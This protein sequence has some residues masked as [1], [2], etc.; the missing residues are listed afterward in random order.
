MSFFFLL[1]LCSV[2]FLSIIMSKSLNPLPSV[3]SGDLLISSSLSES[4][5]AGL[6]FSS[7]GAAGVSAPSP[8]L[9]DIAGS[10]GAFPSSSSE[11]PP[12]ASLTTCF[13]LFSMSLPDLDPDRDLLLEGDLDLDPERDF[14]PDFD[15][16]RDLDLD[17]ERDLDPDLD[18]ERDLD[19]ELDLER[20]LEPD[21]ERDLDLSADLERLL[22][23]DRL[24]DLERLLDLDGDLALEPDLLLLLLLLPSF[25]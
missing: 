21:L 22:D 17:L 14:D 23:L 6:L 25:D 19:L 20:D 18:L 13:F 2:L 7:L 8:S 16:E 9:S 5:V 3:L 11:S 12:K 4:L 24:L 1:F 15:L 10:A